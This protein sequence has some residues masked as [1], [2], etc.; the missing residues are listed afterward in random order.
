MQVSSAPDP[1]SVNGPFFRLEVGSRQ[2]QHNKRTVLYIEPIGGE[3]FNRYKI[4]YFANNYALNP[5]FW[6]FFA[7]A[8]PLNPVVFC[9]YVVFAVLIRHFLISENERFCN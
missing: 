1:R 5:P 4:I 8:E 3:R 6:R 9:A 7:V 2:Q